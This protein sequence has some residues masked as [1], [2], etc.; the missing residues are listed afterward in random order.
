[1]PPP[2]SAGAVDA[3]RRAFDD[4]PWPRMGAAERGRVLHL[5]ADLIDAHADGLALA[6]TTGKQF[7]DS[8]G[9]AHGQRASR[10]HPMRAGGGGRGDRAVELPAHAGDPEGR[11]GARL[12]NTVVLEP[13]EQTPPSAT[14]ARLAIEAGMSPGVLNVVHGY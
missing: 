14:L 9:T 12:G 3:A 10:L 1:M 7:S 4:G 13:V 5:L 11:S 6:D 2:T 8:R